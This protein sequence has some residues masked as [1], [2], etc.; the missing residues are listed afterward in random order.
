MYINTWYKHLPEFH[1]ALVF[2]DANCIIDISGVIGALQSDQLEYTATA[3]NATQLSSTAVSTAASTLVVQ[4]SKALYPTTST[5]TSAQIT[6]AAYTA[7]LS[8]YQSTIQAFRSNISDAVNVEVRKGM[9]E[10]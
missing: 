4:T 7:A 8:S 9:L 1:D 5:L 6:A 10:L 2:A 3:Q